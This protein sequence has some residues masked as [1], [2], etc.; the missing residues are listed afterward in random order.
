MEGSG[1]AFGVKASGAQSFRMSI[2]GILK[3][4]NTKIGE[5]LTRLIANQEL[6]ISSNN[7]LM[8]PRRRKEGER[9]P[10]YFNIWK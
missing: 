3:S 6:K 1:C 7:V 4:P 9:V 2:A 5:K 8:K 10:S